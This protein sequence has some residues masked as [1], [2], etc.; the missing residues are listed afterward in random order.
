MNTSE[1]LAWLTMLII[2]VVYM[3]TTLT[4]DSGCEVLRVELIYDPVR[5]QEIFTPVYLCEDNQNGR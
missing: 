1:K 3:V 2:A 4:H 5:D